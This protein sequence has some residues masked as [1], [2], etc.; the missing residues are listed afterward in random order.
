LLRYLAQAPMNRR[1]TAALPALALA[2]ALAVWLGPFDEPSGPSGRE[3]GSA[4]TAADSPAPTR[5]PD[6]PPF[7]LPTRPAA[8]PGASTPDAA[9]RAA[10]IDDEL[11]L[12]F[13]SKAELGAFVDAAREAGL[14]VLAVSGPLAAARLRVA[15]AARR[16]AARDLAGP[17]ARAEANVTTLLP[18]P[19]DNDQG[20]P[21]KPFLDSALPFMGVPA[22][23]AA[24]GKG[25]TV[26]VLDTGLLDH[27]DLEELAID[28]ISLLESDDGTPPLAHG[29]AVASLV[30]GRRGVA[31]QASLLSV[32]VM[33][34]EGVGDS[35]TLAQGIV[36]AVDRGA[37]VINVSLGSFARTSVLENAVAYAEEKGVPL[38]ASSGNEGLE[39]L[40]F[41]AQ[42]PSVVAA[43][44]ISADR[45]HTPF[46]NRG[47]AVDLA[48][49]GVGVLAAWEEEKLVGFTGT[50]ASAPLVAG[51]IAA[52][53]S[54]DD[55]LDPVQA[56]R[57]LLATADDLGPAG[58]DA[59]TGRGIVNLR[60]A[61]ERGQRGIVD[62]A[63]ADVHVQANANSAG[64]S[65]VQVVAQNRGTERIPAARLEVAIGEGAPQSI[66]L[67][68]LEPGEVAAHEFNVFPPQRPRDPQLRIEAGVR[69]SGSHGD[70]DPRND[71]LTRFLQPPEKREKEE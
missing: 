23:N 41:P 20:S 44:S 16:A 48:A 21:G 11:L 33:D 45:A 49:P 35:F 22:D 42:F 1:K 6:I 52:L 36:E 68:T 38:V 10:A 9:K 12:S 51:S 8:R 50:S 5:R 60:R 56:A 69:I 54:Q 15:D 61:L 2:A 67:G 62:L 37:D 14:E 26:A 57:A 63:V 28:R 59:R 19:V 43:T 71:R 66:F 47:E 32:R 7:R 27:P 34:S 64:E 29:T 3:A 53:A 24:W 18:F 55:R 40:P 70:R 46:A 17:E 65:H 58:P 39:V 25:L 13:P 31:P 4:D 30:A